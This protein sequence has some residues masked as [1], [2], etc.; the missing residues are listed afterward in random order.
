VNHDF[1]ICFPEAINSL[2]GVAND[3][4]T[5]TLGK[6]IIDQWYQILPLNG[7]GILK[8]VNQEMV[9]LA[10]EAKIDVGHHAG[11]KISSQVAIDIVEKNQALFFFDKI[12]LLEKTVI[13]LKMRLK[14]RG[15]IEAFIFF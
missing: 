7:G 5:S 11:L 4:Q 13:D 1:V 10:T 12:K 9:N 6:G 14:I 3:E 2:L 8:L 15:G